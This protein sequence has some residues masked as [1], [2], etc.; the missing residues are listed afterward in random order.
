MRRCADHHGR[1]GRDSGVGGIDRPDLIQINCCITT[2]PVES[3]RNIVAPDGLFSSLLASHL[4]K[5]RRF[6][7]A[8]HFAAVL[9]LCLVV[10]C[11]ARNTLRPDVNIPERSAVIFF[12]DGLNTESLDKLANAGRLPTLKR[13]F[14]DRGVRFT[15]AYGCIPSDTYPNSAS[16]LT[17]LVP[18]RH[19][20]VGNEWFDRALPT[21]TD[22]TKAFTYRAVNYHVQA[23]TIY[24]LI[25]PLRSISM[26]CATARGSSVDRHG[27]IIEGLQWV[28]GNFSAIDSFSSNG[29]HDAIEAANNWR[30]WPALQMYYFPA[31]DKYGHE[32]GPQSREYDHAI[33]HV[34]RCIGHVVANLN[35]LGVLENTLLVLLSDH[36]QML[37][38]E[39]QQ[40][41][42]MR[43][44]T[45]HYGNRL[46]VSNL[47]T[48]TPQHRYKKLREKDIIAVPFRRRLELHV[49][50]KAGWGVPADAA[51]IAEVAGEVL[52]VLRESTTP[53]DTWPAY[54]EMMSMR[55]DD[56]VA[57]DGTRLR[58][59][60][61]AGEHTID[62]DHTDADWFGGD[63]YPPGTLGE[64]RALMQHRR[65]GDIQIFAT[66]GFAMLKGEDGG[67]GS[68]S[69]AE[70]HIPLI[71]SANELTPRRTETPVRIVDVMPTMMEWLGCRE[72][73]PPG[74]DG[75]SLIPSLRYLNSRG[76]EAKDSEAAQ[77]CP[78][79]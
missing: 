13:Y 32:F 3:R 2:K 18:G 65:A 45:S 70:R 4:Q 10:G 22:Y 28:G 38:P 76:V 8:F 37:T 16:L 21:H 41:A 74:L 7:L 49:R 71:F 58:I 5:T 77:N 9:Y 40:F 12:V 36:A 30:E 26:Q 66:P 42:P 78:R 29:V 11:S 39:A 56:G 46:A 23:P 57:N 14:I 47:L 59:L 25:R 27:G 68:L 51:T 52:S 64:L 69:P 79:S 6:R 17:G 50:G 24:E 63:L 73:I 61:A 60:S 33:E 44:L 20:V 48:G 55:A 67:H 72:S 43:D 54:I 15:H 62:A 31:V 35:Q 1:S 75:R 19:G 53:N 34:D